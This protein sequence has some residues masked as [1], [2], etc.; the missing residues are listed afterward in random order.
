MQI[1]VSA[2]AEKPFF[3]QEKQRLRNLQKAKVYQLWV[4]F[5]QLN[6]LVKALNSGYFMRC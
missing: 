1:D 4:A 2:E 3:L 6:D 5:F